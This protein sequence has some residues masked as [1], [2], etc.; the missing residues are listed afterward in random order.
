LTK[1][2]AQLVYAPPAKRDKSE[3]TYSSVK[4][5]IQRGVDFEFAAA[6]GAKSK[7][8]G[9]WCLGKRWDGPTLWA[10]PVETPQGVKAPPVDVLQGPTPGFENREPYFIARGIRSEVE[11]ALLRDVATLW[12][13][14]HQKGCT[15][16]KLAAVKWN[17]PCMELWKEESGVVKPLQR[18]PPGDRDK[19]HRVRT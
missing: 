4:G 6:R 7:Y 11:A 10:V 1:R 19:A 15:P 12:L 16:T 13:R 18:V 2:K 8:R 9:L 5:A 14:L 3:H 17:L